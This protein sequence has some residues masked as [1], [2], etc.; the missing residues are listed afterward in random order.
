MTVMRPQPAFLRTRFQGHH[1]RLT[2]GLR[3]LAGVSIAYWSQTAENGGAPRAL[4]SLADWV[5]TGQFE[6]EPSPM[7]VDCGRYHAG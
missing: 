1:G 3:S 7:L 6:C 2:D 4:G 5:V